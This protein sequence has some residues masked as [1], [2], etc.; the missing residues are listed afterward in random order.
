MIH[1]T[2]QRGI[3]QVAALTAALLVPILAGAAAPARDGLWIAFS[4]STNGILRSCHCPNNPFGGLDRRAWL[5]E[6]LRQEVGP[7]NLVLLDAGDLFPVRDEREVQTPV[8]RSYALMDYDAVCIGDQELSWD[9][10]A[11]LEQARTGR[12]TRLPWLNPGYTPRTGPGRS[13]A[14]LPF[15]TGIVLDR[16]GLRVGVVAVTDP[17]IYRFS[18]GDTPLADFELRPAAAQIEA[19]RQAYPG[20]SLLVVLSHQ[21]EDRDR[22]LAAAVGGIDLIVG[23]H[24][25][26]LISAPLVVNGTAICQAGR[27]GSYLGLLHVIPR[28]DN[29]AARTAAD[30]TPAEE[31][32]LC[33][34]LL[35]GQRWTL[36]RL[37]IPLTD[38]L[39]EDRRVAAVLDEH[40]EEADSRLAHRLQ[41]RGQVRGAPAISIDDPVRRLSLRAGESRTLEMAVRNTGDRVLTIERVRSHAPWLEVLDA[42]RDVA[43]TTQARL[44]LRATAANTGRRLRTEVSITCDDPEIRVARGVVSV[45]LKGERSGLLAVHDVVERLRTLRDGGTPE[46]SGKGPPPPAPD[47]LYDDPRGPVP[48]TVLVEFFYDEDCADCAEVKEALLPALQAKYG[49]RV[50]VRLYRIGNQRNLEALVRL[51]AECGVTGAESVTLFLNRRTALDGLAAI[52]RRLDAT[53]EAELAR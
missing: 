44:L 48:G 50:D 16:A 18:E 33:P 27:N 38:D 51:L 26:S 41:R 14:P 49:Q 19:F 35:R 29:A 40:Y 46:R 22:E 10:H 32:P 8:L 4:N 11:W 43:P 21:G 23:G 2:G 52:R 17:A 36:T 13:T 30:T 15:P 3:P 39:E 1:R 7:G 31:D 45:L 42:P 6:Q 53:I 20:I 34:A 37:L 28:Q 24:S 5:I 25:Q 9:W 12:R 47:D